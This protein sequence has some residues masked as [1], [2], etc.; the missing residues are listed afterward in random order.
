M[1]AINTTTL[2]KKQKMEVKTAL[3]LGNKFASLGDPRILDGK[4]NMIYRGMMTLY[5][6]KSEKD[7]TKSYANILKCLKEPSRREVLVK[8]QEGR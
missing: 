5:R 8:K 7:R 6:L 4:R 1:K 3:I 2:T